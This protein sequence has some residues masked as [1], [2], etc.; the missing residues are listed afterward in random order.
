MFV[1]WFAAW[2][3]P[4]YFSWCF[5]LWYR[6]FSFDC[7]SVCPTG[8]FYLHF[9]IALGMYVG[10]IAVHWVVD[11][12]IISVF[13]LLLGF[14]SLSVSVKT[15]IRSPT[16]KLLCLYKLDSMWSFW[17]NFQPDAL[18][19]TELHLSSLRRLVKQWVNFHIPNPQRETCTETNLRLECC[20]RNNKYPS[21]FKTSWRSDLVEGR[22]WPKY[23]QVWQKTDERQRI[24]RN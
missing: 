23:I 12:I 22:Q 15:I 8:F 14:C 18:P 2:S 11:S 9:C 6:N 13:R 10:V 21:L 7:S 16:C 20:T 19:D 17:S 3:P 4:Y 1:V 5:A 24:D